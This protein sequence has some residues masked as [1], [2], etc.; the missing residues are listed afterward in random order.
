MKVSILKNHIKQINNNKTHR[1]TYK[2]DGARYFL[3]T[4]NEKCCLIDRK[5]DIRKVNLRLVNRKGLLLHK[6]LFDGKLAT[7]K[8]NS[9]DTNFK[10]VFLIF[11]IMHKSFD[12]SPTIVKSG[13]KRII[14]KI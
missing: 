2:S 5:F 3:F 14:F 9:N 11:D 4:F 6:T 10:L 8:D 13:F 1:A 7:E 12:E